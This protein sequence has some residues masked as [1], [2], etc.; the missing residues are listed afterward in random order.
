MLR[1]DMLKGAAALAVMS[2][3]L[4]A[5][6]TEAVIAPADLARDVDVLRQAYTSLHPGLYRYV[7][8]ADWERRFAELAKAA[9]T[10]R[11]RSETFMLYSRF[12]AG[13]RCGHT[14]VS[15]Y[16]QK[17]AVAAELFSGPTR[18]P[19][20]FRWIGGRMVVTADHSGGALMK[21]D[22][23]FAVDGHDSRSILARLIPYMRADGGNDAKR[24]ALL[25]VS[26]YSRYEAFDLYHPRVFGPPGDAFRLKVRRGGAM[27]RVEVAPI[28]LAMR[29]TAM[30]PQPSQNAVIWSF[31]VRPDGVAVLTMPSW[32]MYNSKWDWRT[33]LEASL[34]EAAKPSV[35]GLIVDLRGNE[36]GDDCGDPIIARLIDKP[37]NL[38]D[39][40]RI[41]R[42]R[43]TPAELDPYLDTWDMSFKRLGEGA[44]D[45]G[46]GRYKITVTSEPDIAPKGPRIRAPIV[47]LSNADMSSATFGFAQAI[48]D[49]KLGRLVGGPT[50]GNR[51]GINGGA[52]FFLRL[53]GSGLEAD[54]P[55]IGYFPRTPQPDAGLFPDVAIAATAED[56]AAE[57]DVVMDRAVATILRA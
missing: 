15:P 48:Q 45:I 44:E 25:N 8:P 19:A 26:G 35:K 49:N 37:M 32:A 55:L 30:L 42:Y 41:V 27:R 21:G 54:L 28:D 38:R 56:I 17:K 2:G 34:D 10:P 57:R 13:T 1:R 7:T 31:A 23:I 20:H 4:R 5:E 33:W 14:F 6:A 47:V 22:E 39:S 50:G 3:A 11:T 18:I 9:K 43:T 16:N 24:I 12:L 51:R 52:Y 36:G 53:P 40:D 46:G 29:Q